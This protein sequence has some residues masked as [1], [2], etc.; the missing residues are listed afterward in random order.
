MRI[1]V[2][3][4]FNERKAGANFYATVRKLANGFTR[5]GHMV[6]AFSDRDVAREQGRFGFG[7]AGNGEANRRLV[8]LCQQFQPELL[9][10]VHADKITNATLAEVKAMASAPRVAI[11]NLDPLFLPENPPRIRRF[12]EVAD[13]TFITTADKKIEGFATSTHRT[14]FVPN[15]T[16]RS[17][18]GLE[19]FARSDQSVDLFCSIG[20]EK[21]TPWRAECMRALKAAVP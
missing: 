9:L 15:P 3:G 18:E 17:I 1:V 4:N 8:A 13:I 20:S 10:L 7:R 6:I 19:C 12:G 21:G 2:A 5:N 14:A 16:D 11:V